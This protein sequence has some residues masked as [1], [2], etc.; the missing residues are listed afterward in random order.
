[1][2]ASHPTDY[3]PILS[4][5]EPAELRRLKATLSWIYRKSL[6]PDH[7]LY[8]ILN[9]YSD[10]CQERLRSSDDGKTFQL[11]SQKNFFSIFFSSRVTSK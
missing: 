5:I 1:M 6:D 10:A 8:G 9:G 7:I 11:V 3:L 2:P 4:G